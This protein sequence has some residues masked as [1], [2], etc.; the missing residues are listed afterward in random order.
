VP[1]SRAVA[2]IWADWQSCSADGEELLDP[3][4][5]Q[6]LEAFVV[7]RCRYQGTTYSRC[8]LIWVT[9]D[10]AVARGWFQGYP[11]KLGSV[12]VT[13]PYAKGK[14]TARI[15]PGGAFGASL[16]AYDHRLAT[17]KVVLREPAP[18]NGFV[19]GHKMLHHRSPE[20]AWRSDFYPTVSGCPASLCRWGLAIRITARRLTHIEPWRTLH[21]KNLGKGR[22]RIIA[23]VVGLE[24]QQPHLIV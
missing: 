2:F 5:S 15:A 4:R 17:A 1:P 22:V 16:T 23:V 21:A 14:A 24:N 19:N 10:F 13:R 6:Y 20:N 9:T 11:K 18:T 8:V 7:V 3:T 12:Y